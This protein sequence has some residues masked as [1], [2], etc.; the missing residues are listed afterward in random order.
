M[1]VGRTALVGAG[2]TAD[3]AAA[4]AAEGGEGRTSGCRSLAVVL[5]SLP[6]GAGMTSAGRGKRH[7]AEE[8]RKMSCSPKATSGR[9]QS[10]QMMSGAP[11]QTLAVV[12][13]S[14]ELP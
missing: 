6:E 13:S 1:T 7:L 14:F 2:R 4:A 8:D 9:L 3:C 10:A 12:G 11:A 5:P